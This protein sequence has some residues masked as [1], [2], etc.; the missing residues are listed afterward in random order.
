MTY[1]DKTFCPFYKDCLNGSTCHRALTEEITDEA[2]KWWG[3]AEYPIS[4]FSE[5]PNCFIDNKIYEK[6]Y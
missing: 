5:H 1:K 3:S 2:K 6:N 4:T